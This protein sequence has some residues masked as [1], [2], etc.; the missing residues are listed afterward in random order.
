MRLPWEL[1]YIKQRNIITECI[2]PAEIAQTTDHWHLAVC[3]QT[4]F[5]QHNEKAMISEN[6][7]MSQLQGRLPFQLCLSLLSPKAG[8]VQ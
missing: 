2:N 7:Q 1:L 8:S 3:T 6:S 4:V 5:E